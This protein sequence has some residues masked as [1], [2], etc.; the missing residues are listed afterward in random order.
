VKKEAAMV[1]FKIVA[2][3]NGKDAWVQARG[4]S[5]SPSEVGAFVLMKMKETAGNFIVNVLIASQR[6][7]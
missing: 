3:P 7:I 2:G 4:K 5:Y 1:P 6:H